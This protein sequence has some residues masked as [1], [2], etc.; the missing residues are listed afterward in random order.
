MGLVHQNGIIMLINAKYIVNH[1]TEYDHIFGCFASEP[2]GMTTPNGDHFP[3]VKSFLC[4][5]RTQFEDAECPKFTP[6]V[7]ED[8]G[9]NGINYFGPYDHASFGPTFG[10]AFDDVYW[11]MEVQI[12]MLIIIQILDIQCIW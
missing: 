5:I 4:V 8:D 1:Q 11:R 9:F 3:D 7:G 6:F 12:V 10:W 2:F